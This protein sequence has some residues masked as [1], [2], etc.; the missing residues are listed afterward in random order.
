MI[1]CSYHQIPDVRVDVNELERGEINPIL[2]LPSRIYSLS[3]LLRIYSF[4]NP[5]GPPYAQKA[6]QSA[7]RR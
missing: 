6:F 7:Q 4:L 3:S 5:G 2:L 1:D